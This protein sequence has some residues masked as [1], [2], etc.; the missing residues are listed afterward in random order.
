MRHGYHLLGFYCSL[1]VC[2]RTVELSTRLPHSDRHHF[3]VP[4]N[5][6]KGDGEGWR[7]ERGGCVSVG[8]NGL[9][10]TLEL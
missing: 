3:T 6:G 2:P 8:K 5:G 1:Q 9:A 7:G 4:R 10:E